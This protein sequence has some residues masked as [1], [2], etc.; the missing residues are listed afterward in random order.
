MEVAISGLIIRFFLGGAV[1]CAFAALGD[2]FRPK[3]FAGLFGAAPSVALATLS[4]TVMK[5]GRGY[6]ATESRSMIAG[7]IA[8]MIYAWIVGRLLLHD[9]LPAIRVTVS[10]I[11][12]WL[13][14]SFGIWAL[15]LR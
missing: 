5:E 8:F 9:R 2:L 3:S 15:F 7:A 6:A 13:A 12:V 10:L 1:V 4:L 14:V 11:T